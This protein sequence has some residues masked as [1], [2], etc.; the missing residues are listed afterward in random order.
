MIGNCFYEYIS[1]SCKGELIGADADHTCDIGIYVHCSGG[2]GG[3]T[4]GGSGST[5]TGSTTGGGG[6]GPSGGG[7]GSG[8]GNTSGSTTTPPIVVVPN[9][10]T[11]QNNFIKSLGNV[12][13][14]FY[15]LYATT[16]NIIF[17]YLNHTEYQPEPSLAVKQALLKVDLEWL[18]NQSPMDQM[19]IVAYLSNNDFS[20]TAATLIAEIKNQIVQNPTL[21]IDIITSIKSPFN[22][23]LTSIPNDLTKPENKKFNEVYDA[24]TQ[25]PEFQKLFIDMFGGDQKRFNVKFEIADN[26]PRPKKPSEQDNGQ[27]ILTP[28]STNITIKINK[29]ILTPVTGGITNLS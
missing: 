20:A 11:Y 22:I 18:K 9:F 4:T 21:K 16:Q 13:A 28:N 24:L 26:L 6:T 19:S 15:A 10:D 14:N 27:T 7:S 1:C 5:N 12:K 3:S 2:G 29:Q 8:S 25:S 23:D 17:D